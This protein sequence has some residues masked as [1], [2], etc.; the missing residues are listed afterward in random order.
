MEAA[1]E[2]LCVADKSIEF[3]EVFTYLGS[4]V[5]GFTLCEAETV[6]AQLRV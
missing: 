6:L 5:Q 3:V 4:V 2:S 1:T